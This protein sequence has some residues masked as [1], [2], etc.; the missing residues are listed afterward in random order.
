[1]TLSGNVR[2]WA[3]HDAVIDAAWRTRGVYDV[4]DEL[5]I[6]GRGL[7]RLAPGRSVGAG[8][9]AGWRHP[10]RFDGSDITRQNHFIPFA[11]DPAGG[12]TAVRLPLVRRTPNDAKA[13][14][15]GTVAACLGSHTLNL[16]RPA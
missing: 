2:T 12:S 3:E 7:D 16:H 15:R 10:V 6:T 4:L 5:S 11:R 13:R 8:L 1:M 9:V 14:A